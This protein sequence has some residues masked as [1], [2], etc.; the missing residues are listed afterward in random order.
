[1]G[2]NPVAGVIMGFFLFLFLFITVGL[3]CGGTR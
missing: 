1:M 3:I 2:A